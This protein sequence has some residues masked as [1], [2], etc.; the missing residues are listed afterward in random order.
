M[1]GGSLETMSRYATCGALMILLAAAACSFK[2]QI[3]M[4]FDD[5]NRECRAKTLGGGTLLRKE[6]SRSIY[7]CDTQENL[8]AFEN[9]ALAEITY[10]P[11]YAAG[12]G[13]KLTH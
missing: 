4:S 6:G 12:A 8:Y 3:G 10:Q 1:T 9:G 13:M 5:W 2:P 11:A 7:Y